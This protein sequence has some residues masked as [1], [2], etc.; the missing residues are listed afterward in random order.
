LVPQTTF[1]FSD[2]IRDNLCSG[3]GSISAESLQK[4]V[5]IL[6]LDEVIASAPEGYDMMLGSE[7]IRL[8]AGQYQKLAALRAILKDA[9]VLLLDEVS[10]SMDIES[11]RKLL[12]GIVELRTRGCVT[13][14]VTHHIAITTEP[15]IDQIVVMI[16]GR[17]VERGSCAE[18]HEKRGYYHHWLSLNKNMS[19][20][21]AILG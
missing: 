8:S 14:L 7:G 4:Y 2:S 20:D 19:L 18:L 12:R 11:E 9:S 3:N 17:I 13:L 1:F 16:N 15:W 10:S 5:N 21:R 6:G